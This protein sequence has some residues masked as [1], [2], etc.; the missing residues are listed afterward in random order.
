MPN[1]QN[2][3]KPPQFGVEEAERT[4]RRDFWIWGSMQNDWA[5][6]LASISSAATA[7]GVGLTVYQLWS[8]RQQAKTAFEDV[9]AREYRDLIAKIP[10]A[11][12]FGDS[13]TDEQH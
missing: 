8:S 4:I 13:L 12:L 2:P 6:Q 9:M 11:A 7:I 3:G 1:C 5:T 10:V